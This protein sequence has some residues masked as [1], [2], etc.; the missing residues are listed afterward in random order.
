MYCNIK[1]QNSTMQS[2]SYFCTNLIFLWMG[3]PVWMFTKDW[4]QERRILIIKWTEWPILWI[5]LFTVTLSSP[6][7]LMNKLAMVAPRTLGLY[8][9]LSAQP[10]N[11]WEKH[12]VPEITF[13]PRWSVSYWVDYTELF[14]SWKEQCFV[15][16]EM[17]LT[18]YIDLPSLPEIFLPFYCRWTYRMSN[19]LLWYSD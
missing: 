4:P 11:F 10:S 9:L 16:T 8:L 1:W 7:G 13:S 14:A 12:W 17:E 3:Y 15:L 2:H 5:P 6:N 19:L 18:L